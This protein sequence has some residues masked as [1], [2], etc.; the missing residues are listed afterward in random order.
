MPVTPEW[1][2][3]DFKRTTKWS[4]TMGTINSFKELLDPHSYTKMNPGKCP[5]FKRITWK[6]R[7]DNF[8]AIIQ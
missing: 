4:N 5:K 6:S 3:K 1:V 8:M 2:G 7:V